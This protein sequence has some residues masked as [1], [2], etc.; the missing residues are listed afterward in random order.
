MRLEPHRLYFIDETSVNTKMVRPYGWGR[1]GERLIMDAP[2][3][4]WI[5]QTFIAALRCDGLVS[6]WVLNRPLCRESFDVYIETQL[7]PLLQPGDIVIL[8]NLAAHKSAKAQAI[9]KEKE[10]WMLFLPPYSP[11]LNPIE[12]AFSKLKAHLKAA[13]MRT[14]DEL[15]NKIGD[16]C[17]MFS[18]KECFNYFKK[19]NYAPS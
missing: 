3:G 4:H 15:L 8:D 14:F 10:A 9:L 5:T 12:M 2:F 18:P 13:A 1:K 11:D 7:A 6:P 17:N 19:A 16:I